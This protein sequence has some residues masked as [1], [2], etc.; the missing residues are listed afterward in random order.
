MILRRMGVTDVLPKPV[1]VRANF[2]FKKR[3]GR[4]EWLRASLTG[5]DEDGLPLA[6]RFPTEGSGILR[7]VVVSEGLLTLPEAPSEIAP[8]DVLEFLPFERITG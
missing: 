6:E 2:A 8:G 4:R 3:A 1:P 5:R 7:S